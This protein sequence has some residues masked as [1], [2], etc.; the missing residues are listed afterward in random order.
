MTGWVKIMNVSRFIKDDIKRSLI[1][2]RYR[3]I[4]C[5]FI[6]F[7]LMAAFYKHIGVINSVRD[8]KIQP[9]VC[10][11]ILYM[12]RG[13]CRVT[14]E[15]ITR[16]EIPYVW[17]SLCIMCGLMVLDYMYSDMR[18][19]GKNVLV[20]SKKKS[21]WWISKCITSVAAVTLVYVIIWLMSVMFIFVSKGSMEGIHTDMFI[22]MYNINTSLLPSNML[23]Y[24]QTAICFYIVLYPW[25]ISV[26]IGLFQVGLSIYTGPVVSFVIIIILD[27]LAVFSNNILLCGNWIMAERCSILAEDGL[28]IYVMLAMAA[29]LA[30]VSVIVGWH[31]FKKKDIL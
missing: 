22:T 15:N 9:S 19:M 8:N 31:R 24:N 27:V 23:E 16:L 18:G 14:E 21:L 3:I 17:I 26:C 2:N 20:Y 25:I 13:I 7:G 30:I 4:L 28:N 6:V 5:V 12:T 11:Y 10:D 1:H 29:V